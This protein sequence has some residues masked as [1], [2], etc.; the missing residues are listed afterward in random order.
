MK[1]D[2]VGIDDIIVLVNEFYSKVQKDDL[3]SPIFYAHIPNDW[4]PHLEK[5]YQFWSA[6]LLGVKGYAGNPFAKHAHMP[7]TK[8]YFDRWLYW[9]TQTIDAH[10]EGP[11]ADDAKMRANIMANTFLARLSMKGYKS[12]NTIV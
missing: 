7:L 1:K 8:E 11:V 12:I 4:Q 3:L 10:F 9:F 6:A 5:M 2:I